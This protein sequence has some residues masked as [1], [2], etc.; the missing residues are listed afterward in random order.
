MEII[1]LNNSKSKK[2]TNGSST[3]NVNFK[4]NNVLQPSTSILQTIN[5]NEQYLVERENSDVV[6]LVCAVNP[7]CTNVLYNYVTEVV[8]N[9][10]SK[11][12]TLETSTTSKNVTR[13]TTSSSSDTVTYHCGLDIFNNHLIRSNTFKSVV[14][15]GSTKGTFNTITDTLRDVDGQVVLGYDD[16]GLNAKSPTK[17]LHLYLR[18]EIDTFRNAV[19]TKLVEKNGWYGF[20]NTPKIKLYDKNGKCV[21]INRPINNKKP[22][23]QVDLCPERDLFYITPK[24]NEYMQRSEM[25]WDYCLTYPSSSTTDVR[26]IN[27]NIGTLKAIYYDDTA[28]YDGNEVIKI[29]SMAKHGLNVGDMVNLYMNDD[30]VGD[31]FQVIEVENEFNFSVSKNGLE[32]CKNWVKLDDLKNSMSIKSEA[33]ANYTIMSNKTVK[34]SST[35]DKYFYYVNGKINMDENNQNLSYAKVIDGNQCKYY[36][37]IFSRLPN[38]KFNID[39]E[40]S[41]YNLYRKDSDLIKKYQHTDFTNHVSK[42]GFA[43]NVYGD[44][45]GEIIFTDDIRLDSLKD[46]LGRPLT[47]IYISF[48][49]CN[50]G[51]KEWYGLGGFDGGSASIRTNAK[52][53]EFS[54]VFGRLTCAFELN[55]R[56]LVDKSLSNVTAINNIDIVEQFN[57]LSFNKI[58]NDTLRNKL[59]IEDDEIQYRPLTYNNMTYEGDVNFYGDLVCFSP[60]EC[61]EDTLQMA[62]FRFNTAQ[63]ELNT[64]GAYSSIKYDEIEFDDYDTKSFK[65]TLNNSIPNTDN[66]KEGYYYEPHHKIQVHSFSNDVLSQLP[67]FY[68]K[69]NIDKINA[70]EYKLTTME[71]TYFE[72]NDII[73]LHDV[74]NNIY[75]RCEVKNVIDRHNCV[76]SVEYSNWNEEKKQNGEFNPYAMFRVFKP[77]ETIPSTATFLTDG[78]YR[79]VW[80]E[81]VKNGFGEND[82][83][84]YP[85][86]NGAFYINKSINLY[87]KRQDPNNYVSKYTTST[88]KSPTYPYDPESK[89]M[90][91]E[92][93]DNHYEESDMSCSVSNM[94]KNLI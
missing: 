16:V 39:G 38:W 48:F 13:D 84:V 30:L 55:P 46:N 5:A 40:V 93:I 78:T 60:S 51:Y 56:S 37:R 54:H 73:F 7:V 23:S 76:I 89:V 3:L 57:G 70:D 53:I 66:H 25:N 31:S 52:N 82:E 1:R 6:R 92:V 49:K 88:L 61:K 22:C 28:M 35:V 71:T 50:Q 2:S 33:Y 19:D 69:R 43:S 77:D 59:N 72:P 24:Y 18:D 58:G 62:Q 65:A 32:L 91:E 11:K 8:T 27:Q 94:F 63:R 90:K 81:M 14:P 26:F 47:E 42:L 80:R 45:I 75:Y 9:E 20:I 67:K 87:V 85:F 21:Q 79:F 4:T 68:T 41:E 17:M 44:D 12:A 29:Y 10:G 86:T 83:E 15:N 64:N 36:V 74:D 34:I